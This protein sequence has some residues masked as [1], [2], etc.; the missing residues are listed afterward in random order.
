[1]SD[2]LKERQGRLAAQKIELEKQL[3]GASSA[4]ERLVDGPENVRNTARLVGL[5]QE[6]AGLTAAHARTRRALEAVDRELQAEQRAAAAAA[7]VDLV[8]D[9]AAAATAAAA[10]EQQRYD[11]LTLDLERVFVSILEAAEHGQH[12]RQH[13]RNLL[14]AAAPALRVLDSPTAYGPAREDEAARLEATLVARGVDLRRALE[15][16]ARFR[17]AG[18]LPFITEWAAD[19]PLEAA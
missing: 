12:A 16:D 11:A 10:E 15:P 2:D 5:E 4:L 6:C 1:M 13:L 18:L 9:A 3:E 7:Q 8:E 14:K 17:F 19:R